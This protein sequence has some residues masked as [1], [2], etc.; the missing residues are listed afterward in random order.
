VADEN[1]Y[2]KEAFFNGYNLAFLIATGLLGMLNWDLMPLVAGLALPL[3]G[4][5]LLTIPGQGWFQRWIRLQKDMEIQESAEKQKLQTLRAFSS[6]VRERYDRLVVLRQDI[7]R[8]C[9]DKDQVCSLNAEDLSKLDSYL[10]SFLYF[11]QFRAQCAACKKDVDIKIL[12]D[13]IQKL[14]R[15]IDADQKDPAKQQVI[16]LREENL[17]L[18][19]EI[20]DRVQRLDN[21]IEMVDAQLDSIENSL[22]VIQVRM[23]TAG[24]QAEGE[25]EVVSSDINNLLEGI[26][27]TE[28]NIEEASRDMIKLRK[29]SK[30]DY[31]QP[32]AS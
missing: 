14:Q 25:V 21:Y 31:R 24:F 32:L 16:R 23:I 26:R 9:A 2:T 4:L 19:K 29:L 10:D 15:A 27:D 3:E 13:N 18:N 11:Q 6:E 8:R 1:N 7:A 17:K 30:I 12:Q 5:Y 28:K 22:R 20:L